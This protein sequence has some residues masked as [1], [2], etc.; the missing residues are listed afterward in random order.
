MVYFNDILYLLLGFGRVF[1]PCMEENTCFIEYIV[2]KCYVLAGDVH[3]ERMV[4][5][6]KFFHHLHS[7]LFRLLTLFLRSEYVPP[8]KKYWTGTSRMA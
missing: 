6:F 3:L 7:L 8:K 2:G 1:Y 5:Y 4:R